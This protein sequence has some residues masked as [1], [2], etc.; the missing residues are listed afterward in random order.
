MNKYLVTSESAYLTRF[1]KNGLSE[2]QMVMLAT[3][4][5]DLDRETA[6]TDTGCP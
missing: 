3:I 2:P 4:I 1:V 5:R 6:R